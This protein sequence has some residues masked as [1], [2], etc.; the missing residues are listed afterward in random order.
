MHYFILILVALLRIIPHPF[1]VTPIGALGLFAGTWCDKRIA[2]LIPLIP[3][4]ISD[5]V[6]GFYSPLVM[7]FVYAGFALSAVIGRLLLAR[8][9]SLTRFGSAIFINALI[10]YLVSNFPIWLIY[11]PNTLAGLVECYVMGIP[12][13]GYSLVGD[14]V[15]VVLI[16]G[17]HHLAME[18]RRKNQG[19]ATI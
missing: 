8:K 6:G 7:A 3:L 15:F 1:N 13:F 10:F 5:A 12:Y 14:T 16:F 11:Y 9:R 4:F 17:L 19:P 2:W 18:F